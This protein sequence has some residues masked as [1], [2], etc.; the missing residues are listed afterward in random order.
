MTIISLMICFVTLCETVFAAV[1]KVLVFVPLHGTELPERFLDCSLGMIARTSPSPR[2]RVDLAV[3]VSG[4]DEAGQELQ[5]FIAQLPLVFTFLQRVHLTFR[6]S[7]NETYDRTRRSANWVSGPNSL[8]YDAFADG[9]TIYEQQTRN[10]DYVQLLEA[11]ACAPRSGWLEDLIH[12]LQSHPEASI[13][14]STLKNRNA[15][16]FESSKCIPAIRK[17]PWVQHHINGNALYRIGPDLQRLLKSAIDAYP[18]WPFDLAVWLAAR[19]KGDE[20]LL[21][22]SP[23]VLNV[24]TLVDETAFLTP[25]YFSPENPALLHVPTRLRRPA[26]EVAAHACALGAPVEE[27]FNNRRLKDI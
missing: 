25:G 22:D 20:K 8:F 23:L 4:D 10:Y 13:L 12:E 19:D 18:K 5:H 26:F 1:P 6:S 7:A 27:V 17:P 24:L 15:F 21:L 3:V 14:G 16:D 9:G 2:L 11:D